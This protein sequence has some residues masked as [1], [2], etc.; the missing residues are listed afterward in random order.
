MYEFPGSWD[1]IAGRVARLATE[2]SENCG[3]IPGRD[4]TFFS[5]P[6]HPD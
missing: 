1:S 6:E 2:Q 4:K 3:L 5:Y